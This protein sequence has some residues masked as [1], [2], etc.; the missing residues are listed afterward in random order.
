MISSLLLDS[1][2][3]PI[4]GG[5]DYGSVLHNDIYQSPPPNNPIGLLLH[6]KTLGGWLEM[7]LLFDLDMSLVL[8]G[9]IM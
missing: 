9:L 6:G 8:T 2:S 5:Q 7:P 4:F 1:Y 3:E